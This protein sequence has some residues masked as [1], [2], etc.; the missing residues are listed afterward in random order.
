MK[1]STGPGVA[2]AACILATA[3]SRDPGMGALYLFG[4]AVFVLWMIFLDIENN[5]WR[6]QQ[7]E[8][9]QAKQRGEE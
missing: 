5:R 3:I 8:K 9:H 6:K 2:L 4:G 7:Q 1:S